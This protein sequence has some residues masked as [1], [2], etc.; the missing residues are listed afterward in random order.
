MPERILRHRRTRRTRRPSRPRGV[1][2]STAAAVL[3]PLPVLIPTLAAAATL[4][5]GRRPRLQRT[6]ALLALTAVVAVCGVL[7]YLADRDGTIAV[8]V[9]GWG[10]SVSGM[11]P[12]GITLVVDRLSAMML[13]CRR[14]SCWR[15]SSTP[16]GRASATATNAN[17]CRSS[18]PRTW[19]CPRACARRSWPVTCSTCS[20]G[21]RC[22][23]RRAS[24]C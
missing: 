6:I 13:R 12:L 7:L 9:G 4:F 11:G 22:C 8:H 21:S 20:S 3:T 16:S 23:S 18:C 14:S 10:Q 19:C 5:A 2:M 24:C 1:P 15:W 17:R